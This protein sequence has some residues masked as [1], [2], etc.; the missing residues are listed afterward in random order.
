VLADKVTI[1][2]GEAAKVLRPGAIGTRVDDDPS[3]LSRA[4]LLGLEWEA[5]DGVDLAVDELLRR[6][7]GEHDLEVLS[8]VE[9]DVARHGGD[10]GLPGLVDHRHRSTS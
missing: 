10:E 4:K 3:D 5:Q 9:A 2:D 7:V 1:A 6:V 8:R